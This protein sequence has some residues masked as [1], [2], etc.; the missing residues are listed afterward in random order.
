[1]AY[2]TMVHRL[3]NHWN[4][5]CMMLVLGALIETL[6]LGRSAGKPLMH[7][8]ETELSAYSGRTHLS[9]PV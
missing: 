2:V 3:S 6:P 1:M 8:T 7:P 9:F 4:G 5:N